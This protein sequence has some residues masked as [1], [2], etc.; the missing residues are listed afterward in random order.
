MDHLPQDVERRV[1]D[2]RDDREE[3]R[4]PADPSP[5]LALGAAAGL[6]H[7]AP[8]ACA[9]C[10]LDAGARHLG[11]RRWTRASS[12]SRSRRATLGLCRALPGRCGRGGAPR[13]ASSPMMWSRTSSRARPAPPRPL[14]WMSCRRARVGRPPAGGWAAGGPPSGRASAHGDV[15]VV[16]RLGLLPDPFD[17][18]GGQPARVEGDLRRERV[19]HRRAQHLDGET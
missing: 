18:R 16:Q 13:L 15:L 10:P 6:A 14:V 8:A 2:R 11:R 17:D 9:R 4:W 7:A 12:S 3:R 19:E 5:L 1:V